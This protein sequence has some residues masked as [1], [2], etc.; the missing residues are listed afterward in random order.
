MSS[1]SVLPTLAVASAALFW[2]IAPALASPMTVEITVTN[3]APTGGVHVTPVWVG[4][5][6]GTF[7]I[8]NLGDPASSALERIAEDGNPMPLSDAFTA[9]S[10]GMEQ[11]VIVG[12]GAGA[13]FP[14]PPV[15]PPGGMASLLITLDSSLASSR[16]FSY[17]AMVVPSNDYFIANG[18]PLAHP[19]FTS[20]GLFNSDPGTPGLIS[21]TVLGTQVRDAGTEVSDEMF[22]TTAFLGQ[23][24]NNT[25]ADENGVVH[26]PT[27]S[28]TP[29]GPVLSDSRFTNADFLANGY[30]IARIELR[31]VPEPTTALLLPL[32]G[33]ILLGVKRLRR[34]GSTGLR[35]KLMQGPLDH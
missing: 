25:G 28:Y 10:A 22:D 3:L 1:R 27:A 33:L 8:Y 14:P 2:M 23:S 34:G 35:K 31:S 19:V 21:F 16:Y 11:G 15:I 9:S 26:A 13:G 32:G 24:M 20:G 5:H 30:Q 6:D 29:G 7:D 4:F 18:D 12:P 17:A